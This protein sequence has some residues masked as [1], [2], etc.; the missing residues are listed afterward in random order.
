MVMESFSFLQSIVVFVFLAHSTNVYVASQF[1]GGKISYDRPF[2]LGET[3]RGI[4]YEEIPLG[5]NITVVDAYWKRGNTEYCHKGQ[6]LLLNRRYTCNA[7]TVH[8]RTTF[9]LRIPDLALEDA[10]IYLCYL[11][12]YDTLFTY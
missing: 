2:R 12:S 1:A 3:F 8:N 7:T 4:C 10:G 5:D 6:K 9:E 11:P